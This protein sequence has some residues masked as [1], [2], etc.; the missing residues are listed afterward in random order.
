MLCLCEGFSSTHVASILHQFSNSSLNDIHESL[1]RVKC[2][3]CTHPLL[4]HQKTHPSHHLCDLKQLR[5]KST[6]SIQGI[7]LPNPK[8]ITFHV[9][10]H[11]MTVVGVVKRNS[12]YEFIC[13][14]MLIAVTKKD[15][16]LRHSLRLHGRHNESS[17]DEDKHFIDSIISLLQDSLT[18]PSPLP[19]VCSIRY[20]PM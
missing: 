3:R 6:V 8:L 4:T 11:L 19:Q 16:K 17:I 10:D 5:L 14:E 13:N 1:P 15:D 20:K 9:V 2:A 7:T 18:T 12:T